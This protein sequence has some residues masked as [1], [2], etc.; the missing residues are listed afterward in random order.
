[1]IIGHIHRFLRMPMFVCAGLALFATSLAAQT[2]HTL[3]RGDMEVRFG[4]ACTVYYNNRG[5]RSHYESGCDGGQLRRADAMVRDFTAD[6]GRPGGPGFSGGPGV[7]PGGVIPQVIVRR[8]GQGEVM[9]P[10]T[11]CTAWYDARGM[12]VRNLES[13]S[14]RQVLD[15]DSAMARYRREQA[16]PPGPGGGNVGRPEVRRI[17]NGRFMV[18][19]NDGCSVTYSKNYNRIDST[20]PCTDRHRSRADEVMQR[21]LR[22]PR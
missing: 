9:F 18:A 12:R 1:M 6:G 13:C 4:G 16:G 15:A 17:D 11:R 3:P 2:V 14:R 5:F 7:G 21:Y 10:G 20:R 22:Q 8:D 19:Y